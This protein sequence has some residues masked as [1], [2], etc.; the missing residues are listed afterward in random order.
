MMKVNRAIIL[1]MAAFSL[2]STS[3]SI[4]L[5]ITTQPI[6]EISSLP[7]TL[8][9]ELLLSICISLSSWLLTAIFAAAGR[10]GRR[11]PLMNYFIK[12]GFD[13]DLYELFIKKRGKEARLRILKSL[14]TPKHRMQI[15]RE[16]GIDWKEVDRQVRIL[17]EHNPISVFGS[18]SSITLYRL[19]DYGTSL[20]HLLE[21]S[22]M[23][24]YT[25]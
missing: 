11:A 13:E 4:A 19:T 20:L 6:E 8:N 10:R 12:S 22:T 15:S 24:S 25:G 3:I 17:L 18:F 5:P 1:A 2:I 23:L 21:N 16:T 9:T 7:V 14:V